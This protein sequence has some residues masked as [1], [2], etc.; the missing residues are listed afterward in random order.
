MRTTKCWGPCVQHA[1][2]AALEIRHRCPARAPPGRYATRR[3]SRRRPPQR[4]PV[5]TLVPRRGLLLHRAAKGTPDEPIAWQRPTAARA[6][7]VDAQMLPEFVAC[8]ARTRGPVSA[9]LRRIERQCARGLRRGGGRRRRT[10][11]Q[12][13]RWVPTCA[14]RPHQ[15]PQRLRPV[16]VTLERHRRAVQGAPD[17]LQSGGNLPARHV[18]NTRVS[19]GSN[20]CS[21]SGWEA[22][23]GAGLLGVCIG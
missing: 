12:R 20:V 9:L 2:S 7:C 4:P 5:T 13:V 19:K 23:P 17:V 6:R 22:V 10:R 8:E 16:A 21:C 3:A 15:P 18:T 11:G 1:H 14:R